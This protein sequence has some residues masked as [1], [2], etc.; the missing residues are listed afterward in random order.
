M[1]SEAAVKTP[2][3]PAAKPTLTPAPSRLLQRTCACGGAPGV[4]GECEACRRKRLTLQR[5][6]VT[7]A[8]ARGVPS[9]VHDVLSSPGQ[10][11][12]AG[13]RSFMESRFGHDFGSVRVHTG[14]HAAQSARA[15]NALAYTVG[16]DIV[17]DEG[18][19]QPSTPGGQRLLAHELAHTVQQRGLQTYSAD[20][21]ID[22]S[23]ESR[24]EREAEQAADLIASARSAPPITAQPIAPLL[25]RQT[26]STTTTTAAPTATTITTDVPDL[27]NLSFQVTPEGDI[28]GGPTVAGRQRRFR[29][30]P[31]YLP[32]VKG[33]P[34]QTLYEQRA[35]AQQ[36]QATVSIVGSSARRTAQWQERDRPNVLGDTWTRAVRWTAANRNANWSALANNSPFPQARGQTCNIDH[37]IELQLGGG[38]DPE[39]LQ[40]LDP[41]PNQSAG[42]TIWRQV[43]SLGTAIADR[44]S[45]PAGDQVQMLF[46]AITPRGPVEPHETPPGATR[47]C[48]MIDYAAR[49]GLETRPVTDETGAAAASVRLQAGQGSANDFVVPAD[50][51]ASNRD[52]PLAANPANEAAAQMISGLILNTLH[53]NN[54]NSA[55]V[56]AQFDTRPN[57]RL[58][59]AIES[60]RGAGLNMAATKIGSTPTP[61]YR[62]TLG[63]TNPQAQFNYQGLSPGRI[64][65]ASLDAQ[66]R[67]NW[68]G[69]I[70]PSV[71]FLP[72][73][74]NVVYENELLRVTTELNASRLRSPIPGFTITGG[75]IG[76]TLAP[77]LSASGELTFVLGNRSRPIA[78]GTLSANADANGFTAL[79]RLEARIPGV[80]NAG[81]EIRYRDGAL[82]GQVVVESSQ[83]RL[84]YVERGRLQIDIDQAGFRPSGELQLLLPRNLGNATLGF[85]REGGAFIFTGTGRLRVPGLREVDIRARYDGTTLTATASNIGF[86]WRGLDGTVSVTYTARTGGE[87][88]ITGTGALQVSRGNVTGRIEVTLH[89]SGRFSGRGTVNY[90]FSIRGQQIQ[91]T[92]GIIVDEQ[93][94]VRVEG[95]L[96]FP[97][98]I[99]LF[100]RFGDD[101]RLFYIQRNIPI[102]GVS[103]GP[104]GIVA[105]IEGG[106]SVHYFFGPGQLRQ[107]EIT[108]AFNPL[109]PNPDPTIAFHGELHIPANA[110]ITGTIGGGL[111]VDV[112]LGSVTGTLTVSA[113]LDLNAVLGGTLDLRYA[114]NKFDLTARP[115]IRSSLDL[116]LSLDAHARAQAGIGR[117]SIGVE[118]SW[119]LG[120]RQVVLGQFSMYAPIRWSSD[121]GFQPP[122]LDQI[123]WGPPP[124][125]DMNSILRQLFTSATAQETER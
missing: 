54:A 58:P 32:G 38:N 46:T 49:Q 85:H 77:S 87:G 98:P 101:R 62:F 29:V 81:A 7:S 121:G 45:V 100:R 97:Q 28:G 102:P 104:V 61:Q 5:S 125:I 41:T 82:T 83:I 14:D 16:Q 2:S 96:R 13:T 124:Q 115:G 19:Y 52:A 56:N 90:P 111:G 48:L 78:T 93:Q 70:T 94:N 1:T 39:N 99:E 10:P 8:P 110:G 64:T 3:P 80:D 22:H 74:L 92:A 76:L 118:K 9:I 51:G 103:I 12:D 47:S 43:Q 67:L 33:R 68:R 21:T 119:N 35:A 113:S 63:A 4:D 23:A 95:A 44:F 18:R 40:A 57:T 106:I 20:V 116:G 122:T 27:G 15:V 17:F 91:A 114:N 60:Q 88:R 108:A 120:R 89:D 30:T 112:G 50:W 105:V 107:V 55:T 66:G 42:R 75:S 24:Y 31:F 79:G 59:I 86:T 34:A 73:P 72:R 11:L 71:P 117:F 69:E 123:E 109:A 84:P 53:F 25:S 6:A 37:I 36:L 65:R 26:G